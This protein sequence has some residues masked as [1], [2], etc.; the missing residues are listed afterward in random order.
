MGSSPTART[1]FINLFMIFKIK[2][3]SLVFTLFIFDF[4]VFSNEIDE[5][6]KQFILKN[7]KVIIE[8]LQNYEK[9]LELER[10]KDN[11]NKIFENKKKYL[12]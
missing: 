2:I 1:N 12:S 5:K 6:V 7:P 4:S 8:S 10:S 11:K 9:Q 3:I